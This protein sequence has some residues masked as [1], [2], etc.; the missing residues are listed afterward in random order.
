MAKHDSNGGIGRD[1]KVDLKSCQW[2]QMFCCLFLRLIPQEGGN[3]SRENPDA[4]ARADSSCSPL[5]TCKI[6]HYLYNENTDFFTCDNK[7]LQ[8][9]FISTGYKE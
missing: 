9:R 5:K 6:L 3:S 2:S 8:T 1:G 7:L 4:S